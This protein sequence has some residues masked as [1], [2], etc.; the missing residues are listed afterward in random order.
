LLVLLVVLLVLVLVLVL[1]VLV[2]VSDLV[3]DWWCTGVGDG[4]VVLL[5]SVLFRLALGSVDVIA[6]L[7]CCCSVVI[8]GLLPYG[9]WLWTYGV[10]LLI[11]SC[12]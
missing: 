6:L 4:N 8:I 10:W 11:C 3:V 9:L 1:V 5:R 2:L 7:G 12:G